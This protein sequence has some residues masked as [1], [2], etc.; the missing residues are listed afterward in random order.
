MKTSNPM[1]ETLSKTPQSSSGQ[2]VPSL[3]LMLEQV[4]H[5]FPELQCGVI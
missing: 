3:L 4:D 1:G 5:L 2:H